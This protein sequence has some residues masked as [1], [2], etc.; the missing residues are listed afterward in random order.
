MKTLLTQRTWSHKQHEIPMQPIKQLHTDIEQRVSSIR[1]GQADWLCRAGCAGCCQRLAEI[2]RLTEA[3]WDCL[4]KGLL[5]LPQAQQELIGRS[6]RDLTAQ[7]TRP[8]VCPFL[9]QVAG[10]CQVYAHR[11]IACRTYGFYVQRDKGLYCKEIE[12]QVDE[13]GLDHVIWGNHDVIDRRL[14]ELGSSR[15]LTE[16]FEEL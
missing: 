6:V 3:E 12:N 8:I 4:R 16:W 13:G 7:S 15:E 14:E 11:P 9:N 1:E 2:P 5:E 10:V